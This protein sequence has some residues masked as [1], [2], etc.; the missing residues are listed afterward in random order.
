MDG[1]APKFAGLP[2]DYTRIVVGVEREGWTRF[3]TFYRSPSEFTPDGETRA[4]DPLLLYFTSGTVAVFAT[5]YLIREGLA[6]DAPRATCLEYGRMIAPVTSRL[7][8]FA[9]ELQQAA[10]FEA[11]LVAT[12]AE[13]SAAVGY[14]HAWLFVADSE[15]AREIRLIDVAGSKREAAWEHAPVLS[16]EQDAMLQG[17]R[18]GIRD[19]RRKALE[20]RLNE[21]AFG[22]DSRQKRE[23]GIDGFARLA[24]L[25][26]GHA[27]NEAEPPILLL[28]KLLQVGGGLKDVIHVW[29]P[30]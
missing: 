13:V 23:V 11:L 10:T 19:S 6:T 16:T 3:E 26:E 17:K 27:A 7:L 24:P 15:D 18:L 9:R 4:T 28:A 14:H 20:Q 29:R 21:I 5:N 8:A 1:G 2:G 25:H 22:S 12:Q 30:A